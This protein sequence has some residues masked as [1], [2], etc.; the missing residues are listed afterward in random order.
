MA[1]MSSLRVEGFFGYAQRRIDFNSV[2]PTILTGPNGAGKTQTLR[3]VEALLQLDLSALSRLPLASASLSFTD[4]SAVEAV[5]QRGHD[6]IST[7]LRLSAIGPDGAGQ[8]EA[9]VDAISLRRFEQATLERVRNLDRVGPDAYIDRQTGFRLT[10]TEAHEL[11]GSRSAWPGRGRPKAFGRVSTFDEV[12]DSTLVDMWPDTPC[13]TIDTKRLDSVVDRGN[14]MV[15]NRRYARDGE[16]LAASRIGGYLRRIGEQVEAARRHAIRVNQ[17]AD[18]SFAARALDRAHETVKES[19]LRERYQVLVSQSEELAENGLHFGEAP[20][21]LRE[22]RMSPTEKRIL[23]VFLEDWEKRLRP[24][25][26][27]NHKIDLFRSLIDGKLA[28]SYKGTSPTDAGIAVTNSYGQ[29]LKV[30]TLSSGEQHLVAIF[31]QLL[32]DTKPGSVVLI[33]EPEIS[34]HSAWQHEFIDDLDRV[35]EAVPI[36]T[37][38]ATHSPSI[39]NGKWNLE[40]PLSLSRPPAMEVDDLVDDED[41]GDSHASEP[42]DDV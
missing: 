30:S 9:T 23:A 1:N 10:L 16:K 28:Q 36:Q 38:I 39:V 14:D 4:G 8:A 42:L 37:V 24:L 21:A 33:D 40:V 29:K 31:T 32:F 18:S 6:S 26:P 17:S 7:G 11:Y 13:I 25:Q 2:E 34:L 19:D 12:L 41:L 3:I 20:P 35:G 27:I 5:I 15:G 22:E